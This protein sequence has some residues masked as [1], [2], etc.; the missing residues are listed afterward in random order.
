MASAGVMNRIY[1]NR[2]LAG[3]RYGFDNRLTNQGK[4][5]PLSQAAGK[6]QRIIL[7]PGVNDDATVSTGR[8]GLTILAVVVIG[9]VGL[10][11]W[12]H[13]YQG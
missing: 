9:L 11:V 5:P 3:A 8:A 12:T 4:L 7:F 6:A 10:N 1:S 2:N 13:A